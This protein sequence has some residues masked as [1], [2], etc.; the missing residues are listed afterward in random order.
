MED[1]LPWDRPMGEG[2]ECEKIFLCYELTTTSSPSAYPGGA[3]GEV[4]KLR[5]KL[6]LGRRE[7]LGESALS[8]TF[9]S[10]YLTLN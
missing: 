2:E 7:G 8:S 4:E 3:E 6:N 10:H 1:C 9:I 5:V